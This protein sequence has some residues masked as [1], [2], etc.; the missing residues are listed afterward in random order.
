MRERPPKIEGTEE[1]NATREG[2][3]GA[4]KAASEGG[5]GVNET[6]GQAGRWV[7][8]DMVREGKDEER[9]RGRENRAVRRNQSSPGDI[10]S[11]FIY[12]PYFQGT[13]HEEGPLNV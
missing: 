6:A 7:V 2:D 11:L 3:G 8:G 9:E 1:A 4:E 10:H 5:G 12:S 13:S